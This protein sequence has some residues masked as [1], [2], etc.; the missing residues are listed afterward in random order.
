MLI[1]TH[2]HINFRAFK[3]D[4]DKVIQNT[5]KQDVWMILPSSQRTTSQRAVR[6]AEAYPKGVYAAVGLHPVHLVQRNV[7]ASEVQMEETKAQDWMEFE[8]RAEEFD[9][10]FYASLAKSSKKVVAIGECGL[11]SFGLPKRKSERREAKEKQKEVLR[12]HIKLAQELDLP[13]IFHCR[14]ALDSLADLLLEY[15]GSVRGVVHSFTGTV[16]QAYRFL[17]MGLYV[18]FNGIIFKD[19]PSLPDFSQVISSVPLDRIVV[20]TDAPYL[21]VPAEVLTKAGSVPVERNEPLF[22]RYVAEEVARI[23]GITFDEIASQTTHNAKTL[24]N[25]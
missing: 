18:G 3:D 20:E 25:I 24:F 9:S 11:D 6:I 7:K 23:K 22:V 2:T 5:L 8:T 13:V 17:Q 21:A 16:E 1:D 12:E 15:K 10:S 4:A 14:G 19:R